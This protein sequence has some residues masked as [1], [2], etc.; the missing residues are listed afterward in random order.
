MSIILTTILALFLIKLL[1]DSLYFAWL[2][3][4]KEYRADRMMSY[5]KENKQIIKNNIFYLVAL[6]LIFIFCISAPQPYGTMEPTGSQQVSIYLALLFFTFTFLQI[7]GEIKRRS[8]KRPKLTFRVLLTFFMMIVLYLIIVF[9]WIP[10]SVGMTRSAV[11]ILLFLFLYLITPFLITVVIL[12]TNPFFNFQK[13]R[14]IKR[15]SLK[16]RGLRKIK[17]IGITG[18]YGKTSTKEFL[19]AILN[20]KYKV[21]KT[22]GNNNTNIGVAYTVLNKVNDEYDYFI[23]EMGAYKIG[24]IKE[25]C[26]IVQPEI[27]ILTGI[28]EQHLELFGSI[29]NTI[30]AKFELIEALPKDGVAVLNGNNEY[31]KLGIKNQELRIKNIKYFSIDDAENI[32]VFQDYV[33]FDYLWLKTEELNS[34]IATS[35]CGAPRNDS[36][37]VKFKLNLLGKHYIENILSAIIVAEHLGM[38]LEEISR[39]V[40]KIKPSKFM[41]R[42][43]DGPNSSVF[44]DDSYS[45]NPDGVIAALDYLDEAYQDY[46]KI[47]VFPGII[48]LGNKS[49]EV[50]RKLFGRI[51]KVCDVAY[52]MGIKNQELGIKNRC[53]F[54]FENDFGK[55]A[56]MLKNNLDEKTVVLFESRGARVV[57]GKIKIR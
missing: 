56:E 7:L 18:S 2:W 31:I 37:V 23:C 20:E 43:L 47:I 57:M 22:E 24:E 16:M 25:M 13:K 11:L 4:I 10:A 29:E 39:A 5:L 44:I 54:I 41:M 12:S 32:K 17:V 8:F 36:G 15:A 48:E 40:E 28:N 6:F 42:K 27:G 14:I 46:K 9:S 52:I 55:V 35:L 53:K 30:K 45:A 38:D 51:E 33:E 26:E 19:Y 21:V 1:R 34:G 3:Q 50:H 49:E